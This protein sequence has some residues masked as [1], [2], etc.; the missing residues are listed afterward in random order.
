[1][2]TPRGVRASAVVGAACA[3]LCASAAGGRAQSLLDRPP[4]LS[5]G[6]VGSSGQLYF[7]FL[8]RFTASDAPERKV[9]NVPTF[10]LAAGLPYSTLVGLEYATNS[11]LAS[12]YPNE[13]EFFA[14]HA[15]FEQD[16]GAPLDLAAQAGY[17]LAAKGV[18]GE[19]SLARR[20]GP[21]RLIAAGRTLSSP[22]DGGDRRWAVAGGG[23]LRI[24]RFVALAG[25]VGTLLDRA[26]DEKLAWSAG[27]HLAIPGT[28][29]TLSLHA[30]NTNA[31][32]LQGVSRGEGTRRYGFE[33]TIPLTLNRWFG[34][35]AREPAAI[36]SPAAPTVPETNQGV[37]RVVRAGMRNL[38][39][40][41]GRVEIEA[42][43]TVEWTNNDPL[44]HSVTADDGSFASGLIGTGGTWRHTF[45][46]PGTYTYHCT[47]HPFMKGTVVVK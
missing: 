20:A 15:V 1:M 24:S 25:D 44:Q 40:V 16:R 33:F 23:T 4:N 21:L 8:H 7:N 22:L 34:R 32:T 9:S 29:H 45:A 43:T 28:P 39:F 46:R 27:V 31:Y 36:P 35:G 3:L 47:P 38:A 18:D 10:T 19:L 12:G 26:E 14:R 17:N 30:A 5:G 42:G 37:G 2:K 11:T 13:W 6:W 41:P